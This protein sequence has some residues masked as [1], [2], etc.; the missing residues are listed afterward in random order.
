MMAAV[1]ASYCVAGGLSLQQAAS[2]SEATWQHLS[3]N[4]EEINVD[5]EASSEEKDEAA[6]VFD[7]TQGTGGT[8]LS[9]QINAKACAASGYNMSPL[10][11]SFQ[12]N[13][14]AA[15]ETKDALCSK[16]GEAKDKWIQTNLAGGA[17][18]QNIFS[19]MCLSGSK[20]QVIEPLAGILRDPRM[21]CE[22][23]SFDE[24]TG[25]PERKAIVFS[26]DWLVLADNNSYATEPGAKRILFDAGGTRFMDATHFFASSYSLRGLPFDEI[27]VWE[28]SKQKPRAY[29]AGAEASVRTR[30]EPHVTFYNGIPVTT[31][32]GSK[33]NPV[34]RIHKHCR[35]KDFCAFKLD[36]DTPSVERKLVEQLQANP[37]NLKEFF[38]EHHVFGLMETQ[39]WGKTEGLNETF[40]DSY[41]IFTDLRKKGVRAH[42]WI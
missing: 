22:N 41:R 25:G 12:S 4:D 29:W 10:E 27:Y 17:S 6:L 26:I 2:Q 7:P 35:P 5:V 38:F 15:T 21:L 18:D 14:L 34:E 11:T 19:T 37:G 24:N 32:K 28:A 16:I 31:E 1:F 30:W 13:P 9:T 36:I 42:S 23:I 39:G 33:H 40:A 8:M 3:Q 20:P